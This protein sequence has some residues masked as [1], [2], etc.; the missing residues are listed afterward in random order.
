V[1]KQAVVGRQPELARID[2][3]L[4]RVPAGSSVLVIEGDPG[5]GKTTLWL[6]GLEAATDRAWRVLSARPSDAEATY[7]YAGIGDLLEGVDEGALA[8]L[9]AP[10]RRAL[11][12]ALLREE[13][14]GAAPDPRTVAAAFLNVLRGLA[15]AG[16]ILIVVDDIQWLDSPS[17]LA[18]GFAIR[19]LDDEPIGVLLARRIE[20]PAGL[21][22]GLGRPLPGEALERIAVG[23]LGLVA[24]GGVQTGSR[25]PT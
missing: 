23:P 8:T 3:F 22:L 5:M 15:L 16:P 24:G 19:R 6:A 20:E 10:Q 7:A 21:P 1:M 13:P 18:L 9:P 14:V 11:R 17:A 4:A 2:A 25:G 12:V